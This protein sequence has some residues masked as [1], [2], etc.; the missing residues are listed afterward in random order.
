MRRRSKRST[1]AV[2]Q[3][4][5]DAKKEKIQRFRERFGPR[6]IGYGRAARRTDKRLGLG[7]RVPSR[8]CFEYSWR[9]HRLFSP[10]SVKG[11]Q[12]PFTSWPLI[13]LFAV[14]AY[15][16]LFMI[17][18]GAEAISTLPDK[19]PL[20]SLNCPYRLLWVGLNCRA[21]KV[22]DSRYSAAVL[23]LQGRIG[24]CL[25]YDCFGIAYI[26]GCR[27]AGLNISCYVWVYQNKLKLC[28]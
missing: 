22:L 25:K 6:R 15:K 5:G 12:L 17:H 23:C 16:L 20:N 3:H 28:L 24:D 27:G 2:L 18:V 10:P 21:W 19:L 13:S 8:L 14:R 9:W 11:C 7:L 1:I 4:M 26:M